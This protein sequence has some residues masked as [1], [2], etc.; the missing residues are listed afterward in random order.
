MRA[1]LWI[2][3]VVLGGAVIAVLLLRASPSRSL[4]AP[5]RLAA[6]NQAPTAAPEAPPVPTPEPT[7]EEWVTRHGR[8]LLTWETGVTPSPTPTPTPTEA[9]RVGRPGPTATPEVSG[10]VTAQYSASM[11]AAAPGQVLVDIRAAN[12]CGRD[13]GPLDVWFWVAGYRNGELVQS[14]RGH[15]FDSIPR[16]GE[17]DVHIA[18]PGSID[19][20]DHLEVRVIRPDPS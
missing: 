17:A 20:Y 18:L 11:L 1:R 13:L 3:G 10:C 14:V 9:A 6:K 16:D 5:P 15:P 8:V 19:W 7:G 12:R 2:V 4:S